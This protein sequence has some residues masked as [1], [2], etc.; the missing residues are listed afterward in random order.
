MA[1]SVSMSAPNRVASRHRQPALDARCGYRR[2]WQPAAIVIAAGQ[3]HQNSVGVGQNGAVVINHR[4]LPE[5][6]HSQEIRS[7]VRLAGQIHVDCFMGDIQQGQKKVHP[8][9]VAG[10]GELVQPD[11]EGPGG[12]HGDLS[13]F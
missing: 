4:H 13:C 10:Q 11:G 6:I 2:L 8:V 3:V 9:A 1:R 5:G 7:L 12:G